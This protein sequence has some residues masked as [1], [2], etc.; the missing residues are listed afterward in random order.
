MKNKFLS[1]IGIFLLS[2]I[3]SVFYSQQTQAQCDL[4]SKDCL[5]NLGNNY[6]SDGQNYKA[7]VTTEDV[8]EFNATFYGGSTY[9]LTACTAGEDGSVIF[10]VYD[11]QRNLLFSNA[12]QKFAPYWDFKFK[13]TMDCVIEAKLNPTKSA[14]S[15]CAVLLIGFKQ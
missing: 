8:A 13:S 15:G 5:K 7:L 10:M 3:A 11:K 6:V 12:D 1:S 14:T 2:V 4:V 9:R